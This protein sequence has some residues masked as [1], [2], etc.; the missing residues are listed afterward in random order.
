MGAFHPSAKKHRELLDTRVKTIRGGRQLRSVFA[1]TGKQPIRG[2]RARWKSQG[3]KAAIDVGGGK[4]II[5]TQS[6]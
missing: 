3:K 4:K 1:G 6:S 2:K 5:A